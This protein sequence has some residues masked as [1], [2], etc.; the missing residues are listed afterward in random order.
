ME[1][2]GEARQVTDNNTSTHVIRHV[3]MESWISK[4]TDMHTEFVLYIFFLSFFF[5]ANVVTRKCLN[6][7]L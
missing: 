4:A 6:I 1:R 5:M 2:Y 3:H 7:I